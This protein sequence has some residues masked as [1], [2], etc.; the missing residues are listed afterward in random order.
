MVFYQGYSVKSEISVIFMNLVILVAS[1]IDNYMKDNDIDNYIQEDI[2]YVLIS[3]ILKHIQCP[4]QPTC[5]TFQSVDNFR[6]WTDSGGC[7]FHCF[8]SI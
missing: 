2:E 3:N 4:L 1:D 7:T 5:T 6:N 8:V